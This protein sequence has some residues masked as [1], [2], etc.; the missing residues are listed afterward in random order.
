MA[1]RRKILQELKNTGVDH[2]PGGYSSP[3][4]GG[5]TQSDQQGRAGIGCCVFYMSAQAG[6][7]HFTGG[8]QGQNGKQGNAAPCHGA[9]DAKGRPIIPHVHCISPLRAGF[10]ARKMMTPWRFSTNR[11]HGWH[12]RTG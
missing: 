8:Q 10:V 9:K 3:P 6:A 2:Q 12:L 7:D 11:G 4:P 5:I 1:A